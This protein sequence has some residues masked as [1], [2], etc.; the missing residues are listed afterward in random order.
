M[1]TF[2]RDLALGLSALCVAAGIFAEPL[3]ALLEIRITSPTE[4]RWWLVAG[5]PLVLWLS[6]VRLSRQ[7]AQTALVAA[8]QSIGLLALFLSPIWWVLR[9]AQ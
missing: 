1:T 4:F 5:M 7:P 8:V 3:L 2:V 6:Y 9:H